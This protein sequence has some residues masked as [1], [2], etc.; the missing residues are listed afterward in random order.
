MLSLSLSLSLCNTIYLQFEGWRVQWNL[1]I[2]DTIGT[3]LAVVYREVSLI[4][5]YM[6]LYTALC[7]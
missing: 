6:H 3:Q 5:R 7:G 2:V 1:S 4:Q